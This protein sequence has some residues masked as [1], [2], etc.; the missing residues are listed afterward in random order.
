[1]TT[2]GH[3]KG[4]VWKE[5]QPVFDRLGEGRNPADTWQTCAQNTCYCRE[6]SRIAQRLLRL[7]RL[8][9]DRADDVLQEALVLLCERLKTKPTLGFDASRGPEESVRWLRKVLRSHCQQVLRKERNHWRRHG[10]LNLQWMETAAQDFSW[11][12]EL[13]DGIRSLPQPLGEVVRAFRRLG[14]VR[15]VAEEL[16]LKYQLAWHRLHDGVEQ[17]RERCSPLSRSGRLPGTD[18]VFQKW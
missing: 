14:S 6:L 13:E 16:G 3:H 12:A 4:D 7:Y 11:S 18:N 9:A 2:C 8:P 15:Q 17:L 1:M 10:D 5:L